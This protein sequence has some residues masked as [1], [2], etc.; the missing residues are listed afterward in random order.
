MLVL[1][2]SS[3]VGA[4]EQPSIT[5]QLRTHI[6][7]TMQQYIANQSVDG[8]LFVY[9]AVKNKLLELT[10][11]RLHAGVAKKGDFY[12]SCADFIDQDGAKVDLDFM[13]RPSGEAFIATQAIV[14]SIEGLQR[15]YHVS[16]R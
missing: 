11:K 9:D 3:V 2:I 5:G 10:F 12:V 1:T 8:K 13:V 7:D 4:T 6:Q 16:D 14:H 15:A